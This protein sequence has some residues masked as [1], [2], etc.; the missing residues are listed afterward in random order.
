[1]ANNKVLIKKW[2]TDIKK[3][4]VGKT[5]AN[6][7]YLTDKEQ[8]GMG[9]YRKA[10]VIIFTDGSYMFPSADDEGNDAGALFTNFK[11]LETIPVI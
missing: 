3:H 9:W 8:Q 2:E 7:R 6:V 4:L 1:M 11:G 10:L 5:V